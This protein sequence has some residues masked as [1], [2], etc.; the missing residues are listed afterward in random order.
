MLRGILS[1]RFRP[2]QVINRR[3]I[4]RELHVSISPVN[5][6]FAVLQNEGIVE[7]LPRKGTLVARLDWREVE[8][9][10][11]VRAALES[12]AARYAC[13]ARIRSV[14]QRMTRLATAVD[15]SEWMSF[16]NLYADVVFHRSLVALAGNRSLSEMHD[17]V[18]TKSL[19]LA[20]EA[21][22]DV[23][24]TPGRRMSHRTFVNNLCK[25]NADQV[26]DLV[27]RNI[28]AG[29][30][31]LFE[32]EH[33]LRSGARGSSLDFVLSVMEEKNE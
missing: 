11:V 25:A 15:E 33:G 31:P 21:A 14:K 17:K 13:G 27:R 29:K 9:L 1:G 4:A 7:T 10:T 19:L 18:I 28:L 32:V 20:L 3:D 30:E 2:G 6:A 16:D 12:E 22:I 26:G 8:E 5:E 24:G 23:H